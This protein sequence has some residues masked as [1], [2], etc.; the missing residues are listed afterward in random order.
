MDTNYLLSMIYLLIYGPLNKRE[1]ERSRLCDV[2]DAISIACLYLNN[3]SLKANMA[4]ISKI[5]HPRKA[6]K[7]PG[8]SF[9]M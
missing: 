6:T 7:Q 5:T 8:D 3:R 2:Y 9:D 4:G 1:R